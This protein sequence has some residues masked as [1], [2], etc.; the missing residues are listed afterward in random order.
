MPGTPGAVSEKFSVTSAP[1]A[2]EPGIGRRLKPHVTLSSGLIV[3]K[4]IK[5]ASLHVF[6]PALRNVSDAGAVVPAAS[7][8]GTSCASNTASSPMLPIASTLIDVTGFTLPKC[9]TPSCTICH[10]KS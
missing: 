5:F 1:G 8:S 6:V 3:A 10:E 7:V 4:R 2:T 9:P